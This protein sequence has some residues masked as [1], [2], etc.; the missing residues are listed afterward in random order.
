VG[1]FG[2]D[3]VLTFNTSATRRTKGRSKKNR[4]RETEGNGKSSLL[5]G[6]AFKRAFWAFTE[7]RGILGALG[8]E[9]SFKR[10]RNRGG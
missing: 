10:K 8:N 5:S 3:T 7:G 4:F 2:E 1:P 6:T 9:E